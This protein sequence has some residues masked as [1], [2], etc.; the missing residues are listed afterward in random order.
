MPHMSN[1]ARCT[2][3]SAAMMFGLFLGCSTAKAVTVTDPVGVT[4]TVPVGMGEDFVVT[5]SPVGRDA[6]GEFMLATN[7][8]I[9]VLRGT[10]FGR[11]IPDGNIFGNAG[12]SGD[13]NIVVFSTS[14]CPP[15]TFCGTGAL[16]PDLV[17]LVFPGGSFSALSMYQVTFTYRLPPVGPDAEIVTTV[18]GI[19]VQTLTPIPGPIVGAG[20]PGLI[21][22]SGG[23]LA[24]WRRRQKTA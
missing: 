2:G 14:G 13:G 18:P 10:Q 19:N 8:E 22:A 5:L 9:E 20:L 6:A 16:F 24:W 3:I 11:P 7:L 23:L 1:L 12:V 15:S 4:V 17:D 21:L